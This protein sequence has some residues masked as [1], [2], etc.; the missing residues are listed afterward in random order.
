MNKHI[1]TL[2]GEG[3]DT[4]IINIFGYASRGVPGIDIIGIPHSR[5]LKEK[6]IYMT[7]ILKI[8]M[9][10][11]KYVL[12]ADDLMASRDHQTLHQ[13]ELPL[14]LLLLALAEVIPLRQL[15]RTLA[16]GHIDFDLTLYSKDLDL[17]NF[18]GARHLILFLARPELAQ[19]MNT[20]N[21][22][23][24]FREY[25]RLEVKS[26]QF[27]EKLIDPAECKVNPPLRNL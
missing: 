7:R 10:L 26:G 16:L 19:H 4:K 25:Q 13:F 24:L 14:F 27:K 12:C 22:K 9:P 2:F 6:L 15:D 8:K 17:V 11:K 1:K 3:R 21:L 5:A 20:I 23:E 18:Q